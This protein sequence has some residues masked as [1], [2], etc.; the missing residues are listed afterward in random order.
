MGFAVALKQ[1]YAAILLRARPR[2][3]NKSAETLKRS[4]S[5]RTID[6]LKSLFAGQDLAHA[7]GRAK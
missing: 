2:E 5:L 6:M 4:R 3:T 1:G 7:A